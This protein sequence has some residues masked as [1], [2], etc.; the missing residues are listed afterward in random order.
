M[1]MVLLTQ[2]Y[3]LLLVWRA[4]DSA[5]FCDDNIKIKNRKILAYVYI[6]IDPLYP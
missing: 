6:F 2:L 3:V 5:S 4:D 1:V